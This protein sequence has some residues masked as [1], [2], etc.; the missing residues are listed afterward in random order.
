L[1]SIS[2][3]IDNSG[4]TEIKECTMREQALLCQDDAGSIWHDTWE[5]AAYVWHCTDQWH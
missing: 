3:P 5:S 2:G 4:Y 1:A